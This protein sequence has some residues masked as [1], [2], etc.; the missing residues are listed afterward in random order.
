MMFRL[1]FT[2]PLVPILIALLAV[3]GTVLVGTALFLSPREKT[4]SE[5]LPLQETVAFFHNLTLADAERL[6]PRF[7]ILGEISLPREGGTDVG[8]LRHANGLYGWVVFLEGDVV[9]TI[10]SRFPLDTASRVIRGSSGALALLA[11]PEVPSLSELPD[12]RTLARLAPEDGS[13]VFLTKNVSFSGITEEDR[14]LMQHLRDRSS[15]LV[16][17][18]TASAAISF[19]Y[20]IAGIAKLSAAPPALTPSPAFSVAL[21]YPRDTLE[22]IALL[23]SPSASLLLEGTLQRQWEHLMGTEA[24]AAYDLLPLLGREASVSVLRSRTGSSLRLLLQTHTQDPD[25]ARHID[26][27]HRSVKQALSTQRITRQELPEGFA[28]TTIEDDPGIIEQTRTQ[29][30]AWAVRAT[31]RSDTGEGLWTA[32]N[33]RRLLVTNDAAWAGQVT[34]KTP[35]LPGTLPPGPGTTVMGGVLERTAARSF[36]KNTLN[37]TLPST[38]LATFAPPGDR[39]LWSVSHT[40]QVATVTVEMEN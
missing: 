21:T 26:L 39:F 24:S 35:P 4:A 9:R 2:H 34:G 3:T 5:L 20:P 33:G 6:T 12:Y 17:W 16:Q 32:T 28:I 22:A 36:L 37:L 10:S 23:P 1:R 40:G 27:L 30:G 15:L 31:F 19:I 7:P 29:S 18:G 38:L 25:A 13:W 8:I 14:L 11:R